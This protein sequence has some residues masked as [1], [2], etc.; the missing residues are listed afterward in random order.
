MKKENKKFYASRVFF[1]PR[2]FENSHLIVYNVQQRIDIEF[3]VV[4][5]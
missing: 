4:V 5:V 3:I 1:F 2:L